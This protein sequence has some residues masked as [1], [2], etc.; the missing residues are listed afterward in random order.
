MRICPQ[1]VFVVCCIRLDIDAVH[2]NQIELYCEQ[3]RL[4]SASINTIELNGTKSKYYLMSNGSDAEELESR[5]ANNSFF[6]IM[7]VHFAVDC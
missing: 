3:V 4:N 2:T 1:T 7:C 5:I 6:G